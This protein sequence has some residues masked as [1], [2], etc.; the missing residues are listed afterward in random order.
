[1]D[2]ANNPMYQELPTGSD[3]FS[4]ADE[5][6]Y[7]DLKFSNGCTGNLE[8]LRCDKSDLI[9]KINLKNLL[10]KTIRLRFWGYSKSEYL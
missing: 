9:L 1:M 3:Y 10:A 8:R 2:Y 6:I 7:I 5:R 4:N